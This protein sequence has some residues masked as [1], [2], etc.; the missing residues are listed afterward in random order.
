[1]CDA[2]CI[3]PLKNTQHRTAEI[4]RYLFIH[5][6]DIP[7]KN[8]NILHVKINKIFYIHISHILYSFFCHLISIIDTVIISN[9]II[10]N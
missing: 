1:M 4:K 2:T 10:N 7:D 8:A 9:S 3:F 6:T 5:D